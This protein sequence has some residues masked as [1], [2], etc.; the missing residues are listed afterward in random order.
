MRAKQ[1]LQ[2]GF[3]LIELLVSVAV[4]ALL[5][6]VLLP[7]L[8]GARDS[9]RMT[10]CRANLRQWAVAVGM[11][12]QDHGG[13]LPRRGQGVQATTNITRPE[14]WFNALPPLLSLPRYSDLAAA[15]Q[16]P[17]PGD[18]T[19]WMCPQAE[20]SDG[21]CYFAYGMNMRLSVWNAPQP[22]RIDAV[23]QP[24]VQ[25]FLAEGSG[26]YCSILPAVYAYSPVARH[27]GRTAIAF[28]DGHVQAFSGQ[29]VGCGRGDPQRFDVQWIVPN[30]SWQ[31]PP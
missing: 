2:F 4:I 9:A 18:S 27:L 29:Y 30:S 1:R 23:A 3:S 12:A 14:D 31:P 16:I 11:Y 10:G 28:L 25:V 13:W 19:L 17:R 7:A 22:D 6:S 8:H 15:E 21:P 26:S 24:A 5:I 20:P